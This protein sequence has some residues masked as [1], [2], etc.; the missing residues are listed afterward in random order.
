M[1]RAASD[2]WGDV[3]ADLHSHFPRCSPKIGV[4]K[5]VGSFRGVHMHQASHDVLM[6]DLQ[7]QPPTFEQAAYLLNRMDQQVRV[8]GFACALVKNGKTNACSLLLRVVFFSLVQVQ[9]ADTKA[10]FILGANSALVSYL[11]STPLARDAGHIASLATALRMMCLLCLLYSSY[12]VLKVV[13]PRL[14]TFTDKVRIE[15]GFVNKL[16]FIAL[17]HPPNDR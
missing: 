4:P 10:T 15:S 6:T 11:F 17:T 1:R 9:F 5:R 13:R 16:T 2:R 12:H 14:V 8:W 3:P 7:Q